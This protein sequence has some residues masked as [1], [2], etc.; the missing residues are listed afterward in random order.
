MLNDED[1]TSMSF[2]VVGILQRCANGSGQVW[3]AGEIPMHEV[4]IKTQRK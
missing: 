3:M 4:D 1:I 2:D